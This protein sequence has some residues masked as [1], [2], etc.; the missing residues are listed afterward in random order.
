M[1]Q[2][3]KISVFWI[4]LTTATVWGQ[5]ASKDPH[6]GYLYPAGGQAGTVIQITAGG[7]FLRGA[8]AVYV[9]G[10]H[11][12]ARVIQFMPPVTNLSKEQRDELYRRIQ[13]ARNKL[14]GTPAPETS[15][16][17]QPDKKENPTPADAPAQE[18]KENSNTP[19]AVKVPDNPLW[20]NLDNKSVR[21]LA[22]VTSVLTT[23]RRMLQ[24]NRQ[25][26]ESVLIEVTI[27]PGAAPGNRE[28]R[29]LTAAGLTNPMVFQVG[30]LPE[31]RE[32]EP[33]NGNPSGKS[34][35]LPGFGDV[36]ETEP[37]ELPVLMNGQL[38][39][40]DVDRFRFHAKKDQQV[41]F[42]INARSLIPYLADAVPGWFQ[43][44]LSLYDANGTEIAF[45]DDYRFSP[46]PVLCCTIPENGIYELEI[47]DSIY[48]GR[49]DFVYRIAAGQ[50]PFITQMFP[51]GA[52]EGVQ[53]SAAIEGWNLPAPT[54][55]LDTHPADKLRQT[56]YQDEKQCSNAVMYAVDT[57]P[58]CDEVEP[59]DTPQKAQR[60]A[61]P[62]IINGRI[63]SSG[64]A[65]VYRVDGRAG[66]NI[67]VE[68]YARR[69]NS[70]LD[71]LVRLTDSAGT[72]IQWNDDYVVSDNYLYKDITGTQTH[73]ADSYLMT[74]L[75]KDGTYYICL[76]DSQYRGG[77]A[78]GYRLRI[79]PPRPDFALRMTPSSL[80]PLAGATAEFSV[81]VLRNDGFKG[82]IEIVLKDAPA[83]FTL[84]GGPIAAESD[85]VR[86][87]L[88]APRKSPTQPMTLHLEGHAKIGNQIISRPV[89]PAEEMMQ[90]FLYRHLVPSQE[91]VVSVQKPKRPQNTKPQQTNS[92]K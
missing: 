85:N 77:Q 83:G 25:I 72:V 52:A 43:A 23:P 2:R 90:A 36:P 87:T 22:H 10:S 5:T 34:V 40:G 45:A 74:A 50:L 20:H 63:S 12:S 81:Y 78:Y 51:L 84:L 8:S 56:A 33:N 21:E 80:S 31:A 92:T 4:F 73:H 3:S 55:R 16:S 67:A 48:R 26:G 37:L 86:M 49:E 44:V 1:T 59:N 66:D 70:P 75:P 68:V 54:L 32:L 19:A 47:R 24:P 76:T 6:I 27:D 38:M 64:D 91:L 30:V 60:I 9:I 42:N 18:K 89:I 11:V 46:D 79:S 13:E 7:Q 82:E 69:L 61:L 39:P 29:I 15:P 35:R 41:V 28:L 65:D 88:T 53:A 58:E 62:K 71:S 14:L 17:L 57:L